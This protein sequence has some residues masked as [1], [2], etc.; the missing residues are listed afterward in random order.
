MSGA[1]MKKLNLIFSLAFLV[2]FSFMSYDTLFPSLPVIEVY[3]TKLSD[4][5][6]PVVFKLCLA[7]VGNESAAR[8]YVEQGYKDVDH[9]FAGQNLYNE[10]MFGWTGFAKNSST[11][12]GSVESEISFMALRHDKYTLIV[13]LLRNISFNWSKVIARIYVTQVGRSYMNSKTI[14][15]NDIKWNS[16]PLYP[17]CQVLDILKYV[18]CTHS[19]PMNIAFNMNQLQSYGVSI[20]LEERNK[21]GWRTSQYNSLSYTGPLIHIKNL[22]KGRLLK[23]IVRFSQTIDSEKDPKKQCSNYPTEEYESYDQCDQSSASNIIYNDLNV[24]PFWIVGNSDVT[25]L[26]M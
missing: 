24:V 6:F 16:V 3:K 25:K 21:V 15:S 18:N 17:S 13:G 22:E 7:D 2:H 19:T 8:R 26:H 9:F 20:F 23:T 5:E 14:L 10:S 4:I 11:P 1:Y 12:L